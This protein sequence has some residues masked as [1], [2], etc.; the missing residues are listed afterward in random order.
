MMISL[1]GIRELEERYNYVNRMESIHYDAMMNHVIESIKHRIKFT[2]GEIT[3][4]EDVFNYEFQNLLIM[5]LQIMNEK[6]EVYHKALDQIEI[7]KKLID[8]ELHIQ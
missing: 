5:L 7:V 3:R 1:Q 2:T 6:D 4:P 8:E